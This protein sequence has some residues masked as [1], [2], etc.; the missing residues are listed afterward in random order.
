[1]LR[2][3][4]AEDIQSIASRQQQIKDHQVIAPG[5]RSNETIAA[6]LDDIGDVSLG[7][8]GAREEGPNPRLILDDQNSHPILSCPVSTPGP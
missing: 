8:K 6:V 1:M 3:E 5:E 4:F 2:M 7:L